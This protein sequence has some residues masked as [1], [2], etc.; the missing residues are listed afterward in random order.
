MAT[1]PAIESCP[2]CGRSAPGQLAQSD[3]EGMVT[4]PTCGH[5]AVA[6]YLAELGWL[7]QQDTLL[8]ARLDWVAA[9]LAAG[10]AAGPAPSRPVS[11]GAPGSAAGAGAGTGSGAGGSQAL[12]SQARGLT[13]QTLLLVGGALLLVVAAAVFAAVAWSS[14]GAAG[15]IGLLAVVVAVLASAAHALRHRLRATAETLAGVA[16]GVALVALLAAPSLGL[17]SAWMREQPRWAAICFGVL[18][19]F[20]AVMDLLSR[21]VVWRVTMVGAAVAAVLLA[22][23]AAGP[24]PGV[25]WAVAAGAGVAGAALLLA[26]TDADM[27]SPSGTRAVL[28]GDAV[29]LGGA[30]SVLAV[31]LCAFGCVEPAQR[32]GWV[33]CWLVLGAA[34]TVTALLDRRR[35]RTGAPSVVA[36]LVAGLAVGLVPALALTSRA[37]ADR[38]GLWAVTVLLALLGAAALAVAVWPGR[39]R[40]GLRGGAVAACAALWA[41]PPLLTAAAGLGLGAARLAAHLGIVG[42]ALLAVAAA[43]GP[44]VLAWAGAAIG[45]LAA[46]IALAQ[47]HAD[48]LET[49][50]LAGAVLLLVAGLITWRRFPRVG[51]MGLA[52]PALA[53]ALLPSAIWS[54]AQAVTDGPLLRGLVVVAVGAVLAVVGA[55]VRVRAAV[56]IGLLAAVVAGLG[57][58]AA[59]A[60]LFPRW[61]VLAVAGAMLVAAGFT[62][63]AMRA[64]GRRFWRTTSAM[65]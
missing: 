18:A 6:A 34:A 39:R 60:T 40:P 59:A 43:A 36:A 23:F 42:A 41:Y 30:L 13:V 21:L 46:W 33:V 63:E 51:S 65:R 25:Y 29:R 26:R 14:L 56:Y 28:V 20:S 38:V 27:S 64:A 62:F 58:L 10:A 22:A 48:R 52:G 35:G 37:V 47:A 12:G 7:R 9:Q 44:V 3:A 49:Y 11:P 1:P 31:V 8:H 45:S 17:G 32:A 2:R 16:A 5:R 61:V 53:M 19:V 4:C 24:G 50:T 54:F 55:A 15:Q 57:Q